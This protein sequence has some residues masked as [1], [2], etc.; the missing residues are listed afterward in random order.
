MR[1]S[2]NS[3]EVSALKWMPCMNACMCA[4][5]VYVSVHCIQTNMCVPLYSTKGIDDVVLNSL[6]DTSIWDARVQ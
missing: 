2:L 5:C 1:I 4:V 6:T 3:Q